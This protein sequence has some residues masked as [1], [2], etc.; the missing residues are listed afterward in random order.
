MAID[1]ARDALELAVHPEQAVRHR[2]KFPA[3]AGALA[4]LELVLGGN[5]VHDPPVE[6]SHDGLLVIVVYQDISRMLGHIELI[7]A[8]GRRLEP[9]PF[10]A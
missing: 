3:T 2:G 5:V 6:Q 1:G 8:S 7:G 4:L 10:K 9:C